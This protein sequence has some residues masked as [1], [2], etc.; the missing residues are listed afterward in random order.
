L[1][2]IPVKPKENTRLCKYL[3]QP[4]KILKSEFET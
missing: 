4:N 2:L 1:S 3:V